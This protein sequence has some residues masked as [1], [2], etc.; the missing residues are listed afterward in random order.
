MT[1]I[2]KWKNSHPLRELKFERGKIQELR[3]IKLLQKAS[4]HDSDPAAI[5][6][7]YASDDFE[8]F[9]PVFPQ[10]KMPLDYLG[11]FNL[12]KDRL[13][14]APWFKVQIRGMTV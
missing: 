1:E 8:V 3:T 10:K 7:A 6:D 5:Y 12:T 14:T 9:Y 4:A 2:R 13:A 11:Q